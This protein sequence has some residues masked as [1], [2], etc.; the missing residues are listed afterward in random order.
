HTRFS[1]DWSS[2]V[3]SSDLRTPER[4]LSPFGCTRLFAGEERQIQRAP[5]QHHEIAP[6]HEFGELLPRRRYGR[7]ALCNRPAATTWQVQAGKV[8]QHVAASA[9]ALLAADL[10]GSPFGRCLH[11][12]L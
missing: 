12:Q 5:R 2:D 7:L 9:A 3:C 6:E 8:V 11:D 1:R 10:L 4:P